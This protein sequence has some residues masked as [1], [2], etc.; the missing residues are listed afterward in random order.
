MKRGTVIGAGLAAAMLGVGVGLFLSET[1]V[2]PNIGVTQPPKPRPVFVKGHYNFAPLDGALDRMMSENELPGLSM[3]VLRNGEVIYDRSIGEVDGSTVFTIGSASKWQSAVAIMS[4]VEEGVLNLDDPLS[5]HVPSMHANKVKSTITLRQALSHQTGMTAKHAC[6]REY[7]LPLSSC[8]DQIAVEPLVAL[9][10]TKF[11]YGSLSFHVAAGAAEL[12][13]GKS[14]REIYQ[15]RV[16]LPLGMD[17]TRFGRAGRSENPGIAGNLNTS[18]D[19]YAHFL[20]MF[21]NYGEI[22]GLRILSEETVRMMELDQVP[23]G[24]PTH[25]HVP[26]R[27]WGSKHSI[28]GLG[29]WRDL[30]DRRG[31]LVVSSSPGK[32]GFTPWIDRRLGVVAVLSTEYNA[33]TVEE[34]DK[35]DPFAVIYQICNIIDQADRGPVRQPNPRCLRGPQRGK[36]GPG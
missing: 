27:H 5:K 14:W 29:V 13:T 11:G 15:E 21:R 18:R 4:L 24:L 12:A 8:V 10:G 17:N 32:F 9:P 23:A 6:L 2:A 26:D 16:A 35:P 28:Y 30:E 25:G 34:D 31:R 1:P 19:D 33:R 20:E 7:T 3:V 22:D 36:A